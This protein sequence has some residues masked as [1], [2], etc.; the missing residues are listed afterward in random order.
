MTPNQD[1]E[2]RL[3]LIQNRFEVCYRRLQ[4]Q[5]MVGII[6][7][8]APE[9]FYDICA[10]IL[11][12]YEEHLLAPYVITENSAYGSNGPKITPERPGLI[13]TETMSC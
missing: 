4:G 7:G 2:I 5:F 9:R 10:K 3:T 1:R 13:K 8:Y 6:R 11:F 12:D